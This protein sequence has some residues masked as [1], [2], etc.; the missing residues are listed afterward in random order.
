MDD[1]RPRS[2]VTSLSMDLPLLK[3][4][5]ADGEMRPCTCPLPHV[6]LHLV[7]VWYREEREI[8]TRA[9]ASGKLSVRSH[10]HTP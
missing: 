1:E 4:A 2:G 9:V 8:F 3:M 7:V 10:L 6:F 5:H